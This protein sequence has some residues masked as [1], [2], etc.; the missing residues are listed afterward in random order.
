MRLP[1]A[2]LADVVLV[3]ELKAAAA[4]AVVVMVLLLLLLLL[5]L[6]LVEEVVASVVV[7]AT[8]LA[9]GQWGAQISGVKMTA[10]CLL[11]GCVG[12]ML[13][14]SMLRGLTSSAASLSSRHA[15]RRH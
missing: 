3:L 9:T 14:T 13:L 1:L 4:A 15:T 7:M 8:A 2:L 10:R 5:V 6:L 12:Q 11:A